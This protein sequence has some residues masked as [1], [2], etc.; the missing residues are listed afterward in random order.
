MLYKDAYR[1]S[2]VSW[3]LEN[4]PGDNRIEKFL[5]WYH[6]TFFGTELTLSLD[7]RINSRGQMTML[8]YL[9]S[10]GDHIK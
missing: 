3:W 10:R 6:L 8:K 1:K 9:D 5:I 7:D 4:Y 2:N